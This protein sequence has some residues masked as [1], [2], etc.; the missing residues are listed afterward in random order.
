M[1][2]PFATLSVVVIIVVGCAGAAGSSAPAPDV[3]SPSP[4]SSPSASPESPSPSRVIDPATPDA[5]LE[6]GGCDDFGNCRRLDVGLW[7]AVPFTPSIRC[8][9]S[10][11]TCQL[12]FEIYAR[13]VG[14]AMA[15]HRA[16]TRRQPATRSARG[17]PGRDGDGA[18]RAGRRGHGGVSGGRAASGPGGRPT[19]SRTSPA[20]SGSLGVPG[21]PSGRTPTASCSPVTPCRRDP[22][23]SSG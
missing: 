14:R 23:R 6:A 4:L 10:G 21:Q 22:S 20:P 7:H 15:A 17:L 1:I 11:Q 3:T 16:G 5:V 18:G 13:D 19:R 8:G 9:L 2:R 12:H